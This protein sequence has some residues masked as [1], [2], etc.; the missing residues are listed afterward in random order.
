MT[1]TLESAAE[2]PIVTGYELVD[3]VNALPPEARAQ[4]I[5]SLKESRPFEYYFTRNGYLLTGTL[6]SRRW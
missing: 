1:K 6:S 5:V 2:R 3:A 4:M